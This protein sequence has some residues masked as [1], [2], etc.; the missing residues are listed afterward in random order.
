METRGGLLKRN[1]NM[2]IKI[3]SA[4]ASIDEALPWVTL[5][6]SIDN[7]NNLS[8]AS[9]QGGGSGD[10]KGRLGSSGF[11]HLICAD[12]EGKRQCHGHCGDL[13]RRCLSGR[14]QSIPGDRDTLD[15]GDSRHRTLVGDARI[16]GGDSLGKGESRYDAL[17][18]SIRKGRRSIVLHDL[19]SRKGD[20]KT[21]VSLGDAFGVKNNLGDA[22]GVTGGLD[23]TLRVVD[24]GLGNVDIVGYSEGDFQ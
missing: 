22:I 12:G 6:D 13:W 9:R 10:A 20:A 5:V 14:Y 4:M 3:G 23:S 7:A 21:M 19:G 15:S 11:G 24:G 18:G 1:E 16:K 8:D 17:M 2:V